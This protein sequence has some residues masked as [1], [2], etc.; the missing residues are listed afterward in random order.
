MSEMRT[1]ILTSPMGHLFKK[2]AIPGIIGTL[3]LGLYNLVDGIFVGQFVGPEALGGVTLVYSIVL[4]NQA[5]L[6]LLG[7]GSMAVL[8]IAVGKK[9]YDTISK[10]FGNLI[11]ILGFLSLVFSVSVYAYTDQNLNFQ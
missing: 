10:I 11:L 8:S 2:L 5:I 9:D 7:T 1:D 6:V 4:I 3:I